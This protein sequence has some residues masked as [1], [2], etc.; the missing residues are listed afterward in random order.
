M[1]VSRMLQAGTRYWLQGSGVARGRACTTRVR[2]DA[3]AC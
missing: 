3:L 1:I 2:F